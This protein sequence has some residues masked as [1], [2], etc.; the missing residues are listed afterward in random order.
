ME[1]ITQQDRHDDRVARVID[2]V[3]KQVFG[4]QATGLIYRHLEHNHGLK[5]GEIAEKIDI[6]AEGLEEFLR[7]GAYVVEQ[8]ILE[9]IYSSCGLL[10]RLELERSHN[11][12]DFVG[13]MKL[14][15]QRA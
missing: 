15:M 1:T 4:E 5:E 14:L 12:G 13:Q 2:R 9:D 3:L 8:K 6:F 10:R 7:S 11:E